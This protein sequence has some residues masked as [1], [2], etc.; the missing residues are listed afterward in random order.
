MLRKFF[1]LVRALLCLIFDP[2]KRRLGFRPGQDQREI[3]L[4]I[5]SELLLHEEIKDNYI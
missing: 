3:L 5:Q 1:I 4:H 2:N